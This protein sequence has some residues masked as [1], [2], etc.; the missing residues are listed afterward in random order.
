MS[1][2]IIRN[3]PKSRE[4]GHFFSFFTIIY[5]SFCESFIFFNPKI[6]KVNALGKI[7]A[8]A[9]DKGR[10]IFLS[11]LKNNKNQKILQ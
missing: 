11:G 1:Q 8:R 3:F 10:D 6:K 7:Y 5:S 9:D 2:F 4:G